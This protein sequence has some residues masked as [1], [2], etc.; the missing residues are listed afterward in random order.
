MDLKEMINER[1]LE[2][3]TLIEDAPDGFEDI[4]WSQVFASLSL[5]HGALLS[6]TPEALE[7]LSKR[8]EETSLILLGIVQKNERLDGDGGS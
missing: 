7:V 5:I 1:M 4:V 6:G 2:I 3:A 8:G